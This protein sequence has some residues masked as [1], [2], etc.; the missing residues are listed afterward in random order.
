MKINFLYEFSSCQG[1]IVNGINPDYLK[2]LF[3]DDFSFARTNID[4]FQSNINHKISF[5]KPA[6]LYNYD[7][8]VDYNI[9]DITTFNKNELYLYPISTSGDLFE[10]LSLRDTIHNTP[11]F[12]ISSNTKNLLK[13]H[14]NFFIYLEH[15]G[16]PY[17]DSELLNKIYKICSKNDIPFNKVIIFNGTNSNNF[18]F[19]D[20][21][22]NYKTSSYP[23][24]I[25]YNWALPFKALELRTTWGLEI[26]PESDKSTIAS[27]N[28]I[29][30]K[31][32]H[33]ALF[34]VK[35]LRVHRLLLLSLL[36]ESKI[37]KD[38]LY[39]LDIEMNLYPTFIDILKN[40]TE[41]LPVKVPTKYFDKITNGYSAIIDKKKVTLDYEDF[42]S[43][44]G[45]GMETKELYENTY[46]SIVA[47]TEFSEYQESITEKIIKPIMHCHPFI[48]LGSPHSLKTL[49]SYGFKT[50]DKWWD[51]S[52]DNDTD[53]WSRLQKVYNLSEYLINKTDEEWNTMLLEM[54]D[55]LEYN[56]KLLSTFD[57]KWILSN[58][59]KNIT[60]LYT[61]N[62][63]KLL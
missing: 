58:I 6:Y 35:R 3:S 40:E 14:D 42:N 2:F 39:S 16:E 13:K 4:K 60:N 15:P 9:S 57:S 27:I 24:L 31:K 41:T 23:N 49:K 62:V 10:F 59:K 11:L 55:I 52:Y 5:W 28:H 32:S 34:L 46:F 54:K 26:N 48:V 51:E 12:Y 61:K 43:V 8:T 50:F 33:K 44:H 17:F 63:S 20:F 38:V 19:E 53:D 22:E 47:E 37:I 36:F 45:F 30:F 18:I 56:Q 21:K 29:N 7:N 25:S 1:T